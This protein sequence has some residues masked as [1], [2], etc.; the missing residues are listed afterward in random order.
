MSLHPLRVG[1]TTRVVGLDLRRVGLAAGMVDLQSISG[2]GNQNGGSAPLK[3]GSD[4][5]GGG[6]TLEKSWSGS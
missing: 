4:N 3:S 6:S 1:L 2:S 5:Q